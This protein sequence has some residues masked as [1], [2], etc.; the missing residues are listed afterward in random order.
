MLL[1]AKGCPLPFPPA[2]SRVCYSLEIGACLKCMR[3]AKRNDHIS[4]TS[5]NINQQ[6][7]GAAKKRRTPKV[8]SI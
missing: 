7:R 4:F 1:T 3:R 5:I 2:C 6:D 8:L